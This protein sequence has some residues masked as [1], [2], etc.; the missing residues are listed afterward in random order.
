MDTVIV[1]GRICDGSGRE[2]ESRDLLIRNGRIAAVASPGAFAGVDAGI[3]DAAGKI[4]I[5]LRRVKNN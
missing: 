3:I 1:N 5:Y 2:P 4:K